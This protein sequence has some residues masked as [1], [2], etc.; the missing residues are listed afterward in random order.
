MAATADVVDLASARGA[1]E[2][3]KRFNQIEAVNVVADLFPFVP[4]NPVGSA[5]HSADHVSN[6]GQFY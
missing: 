4:E 6:S 2:L 3:R 5:T 1:D